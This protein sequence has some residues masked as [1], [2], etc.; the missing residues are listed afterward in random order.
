MGR[1]RNELAKQRVDAGE[2]RPAAFTFFTIGYGGRTKDEFLSLLKNHGVRAVV[3]VRLRPDRASMGIW[4]QAK[5]ADKGIAKWLNDGGIEYR[6]LIE[7]GNPFVGLD[8]WRERYARLIESSGG[9]L[10][11]RL[12]DVPAPYC[13]M[14]AEKR[15][16]E[17]HRRHIAEFLVANENAHV[18]HIE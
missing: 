6:S 16:A 11:S 12:R 2:A 1:E 3:D 10:T 17:C 9:L 8:D 13:L 18:V 5:T 7:L 4:V 15:V 14:C